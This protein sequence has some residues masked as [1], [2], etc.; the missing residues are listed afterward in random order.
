MLRIA[1]SVTIPDS[2]IEIHSIRAQGAGGQHVNKVSTAVCLRFDIRA[3][4]LPPPY[5]QALLDLRDHRISG[6]GVITIKSQE[7]RSRERNRE[8]AV[9]RLLALIQRAI[10]PRKVRKPTAPT[11]A[12]REQRIARKK[13]R[14]R[15]KSQRKGLE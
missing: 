9:A 4:S 10:A 8:E 7:H 15:L 14:G 2:E 3:S 1:S 13:R 11:K 6:D 12:S 5:K